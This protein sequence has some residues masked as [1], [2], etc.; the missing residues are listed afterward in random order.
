MNDIIFRL[1]A[2]ATYPTN[3]FSV[4]SK[5]LFDLKADN[6]GGICKTLPANSTIQSK[7]IAT[8]LSSRFGM[9][10]SYFRI[11]AKKIME[12]DTVPFGCFH[13]ELFEKIGYFDID[14]IR[15]QDDEFNAR[16]IKNGGHIFIIPEVVINYY[17]RDKFSKV[18][19]MFYQY[20]LFKPL[21]NKKVGKPATTRQFFPPLFLLALIT[22]PIL[23]T[24]FPPFLVFYSLLL[25][26]YFIL[27]FIFAFKDFT[28]FKE[29]LILPW[30][31]FIIHV[32]YGW[33]Y[34]KGIYK[35]LL[36]GSK[37][38]SININR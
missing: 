8:A 37:E 16:I 38:S 13:K 20:G 25:A 21:V 15:N 7:A 32:S 30:L 33:G 5:A 1:D 27:G 4:L 22:L 11:G 17:G 10:N 3:Y 35:F 29:V 12:V 6:V 23:S 18:A 31:F 19:K 26:L 2:H 14:L 24:I 34:L 9:G 28:D 36:I